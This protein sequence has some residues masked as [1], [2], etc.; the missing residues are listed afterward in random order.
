MD[1]LLDEA[2]AHGRYTEGANAA[3][4]LRAERSETA[5]RQAARSAAKGEGRGAARSKCPRASQVVVHTGLPAG[6]PWSA[7]SSSSPS[8]PMLPC[9]SHRFLR[10]RHCA[11]RPGRLRACSRARRCGASAPRRGRYP[12]VFLLQAHRAPSRPWPLTR[13]ALLLVRSAH[14]LHEGLRSSQTSLLRLQCPSTRRRCP[15][16]FSSGLRSVEWLH[17]LLRAA[18]RRSPLR[19]SLRLATS[20][21]GSADC[22]VPCPLPFDS[23]CPLRSGFTALPGY[24]AITSPFITATSTSR[25]SG[26][27]SDFDE[28]GRLISIVL[29]CMW[30]L[31]IGA[32]FCLRLPSDSASRRTPLAFG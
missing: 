10:L 9:S 11:S 13:P 6:W 28:Y 8:R 18:S 27:V 1:G 26:Q 19:G 15:S 2:V 21:L 29:P 12:Y 20:S 4:G 32:M 16:L 17:A 31:F 22:C 30:F 7:P 23:G 25:L 3:A 5:S 14:Y 24:R